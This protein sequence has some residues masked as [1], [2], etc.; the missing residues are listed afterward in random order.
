MVTK[1]NFKTAVSY[2]VIL[3]YIIGAFALTNFLLSPSVWGYITFTGQYFNETGDL[4]KNVDINVSICLYENSSTGG[5][6][7]KQNYTEMNT[8]ETGW[9]LVS[10]TDI[11]NINWKWESSYYAGISIN[12]TTY[13]ERINLTKVPFAM[14]SNN[15]LY[16]N[17]Q[18]AS[19]YLDDTDTDTYNT[20]NEMSAAVNSTGTLW[21]NYSLY[22]SWAN[23]Q[24][25]P[26]TI[27]NNYTNKSYYLGEYP[28]SVFLREGEILTNDINTSHL[29]GMNYNAEIENFVWI[30]SLIP[31][32]NDTYGLGNTSNMFYNIF[33]HNGFFD[34]LYNSAGGAVPINT[35]SFSPSSD[36]LRDLGSNTLR[37][38]ELYL[39]D[40]LS[41]N[42]T[43]YIKNL[44][45]TDLPNCDTLDT[46]ANGKVIC[47][48]DSGAGAG[49]GEPHW[50]DGGAYLYPNT[51]YADNVAIVK[52]YLNST[53]WSNAS[54]ALNSTGIL[55]A[56]YSLYS[57]Y[58][59]LINIPSRFA[60]NYTN[61]SFYLGNYDAS[62]FVLRDTWTTHDSYPTACS[63]GSAVTGLGDTLA[64]SAFQTGSEQS[65]TTEEV[66]DAAGSLLG[67]TE[68]LITVTY[69]DANND[70]DFVVN[71]DL[72][73][74]SWASVVDAD[75]TDTLT[76]SNMEGTDWGTLTNGYYC[77]YDSVGTEVDCS[78]QYPV[79]SSDSTWTL[80][81]SYPA[82]CSAGSAITALGDTSTCTAFSQLGTSVDDTEMTAEDF[83]GFTCTAG[84]D[85]C[86]VDSDGTWTL[87]NSYPV[88]CGT[89]LFA[90][91]IGDTL[92]C[93]APT[94]NT[95]EEMQD[96]AG[97]MATNGNGV[98]FAYS[99]AANTLTPSFDCSDV[100]DTAGDHLGCSTEDLM[101][102]DDFLL[103]TGD[104]STGNLT[105]SDHKGLAWSTA[106]IVYS[107]TTCTIIKG[108]TS[109]LAVC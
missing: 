18:P 25:V 26:S 21:A 82:A 24:G 45:I 48:L 30:E 78:T 12:G 53:D 50:I 10:L 58:N 13:P 44:T 84:E 73:S 71:N 20:T 11:S 79:A 67:G 15:S 63:A 101:V 102:D 96:A 51:S 40:I 59:N 66:Q 74:Y 77:T 49:A 89:G 37:Y 97:A 6:C 104:T 69:D 99:D 47:G 70:I 52:G 68:T 86:S 90:T 62:R 3:L 91:T 41:L 88:A 65:N 60:G 5:T 105:F 4:Q 81:N 2:G 42:G 17:G 72:H 76:C 34:Y 22:S 92:T 94:Y 19:Y 14:L 100:T 56:N 85:G 33:S 7:I 9:W 83:G 32:L 8:S 109:T 35:G 61:Q 23:L 55:W 28:E 106:G 29:Y 103:N 31:I 108:S 75:I 38:R 93:S 16:L 57:N 46:D 43:A 107:N 27:S 64:C 39:S 1:N 95:T 98:D 80:H 87:H 36:D 54:S